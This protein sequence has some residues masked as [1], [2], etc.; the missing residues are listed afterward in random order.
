MVR[1]F[2]PDQ[3][4]GHFIAVDV[5]SYHDCLKALPERHTTTQVRLTYQGEDLRNLEMFEIPE[6]TIIEVEVEV[7]GG[8]GGFG[9]LLRI[10]AAQKKHFNNFDSSR[11]SNGRR[12]RDIKN[13][14]RLKEYVKRKRDEKKVLDEELASL[15]VQQDNA[16]VDTNLAHRTEVEQQYKHRVAQWQSD[17]NQTVRKGLLRQKEK[18]AKPSAAP[19][20]QATLQAD[21]EASSRLGKRVPLE[22]AAVSEID[23]HTKKLVL[24]PDKADRLSAAA[25]QPSDTPKARLP[26]QVAGVT[27]TSLMP[28]SS[29]PAFEPIELGD[30]QSIDDLHRLSVDH[31]KHELKRLGLK[32]GGAPRDR[33]QRLWDIKC[34]PANLLNPKYLAK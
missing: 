29:R 15:K 12:L 23:E 19:G 6:L 31:V 8:K 20:Q 32:C 10:A 25:N 18:A 11:D 17:L 13:E 30:L 1:V 5:D 16:T 4:E 9:S 21:D 14:I 27:A 33:V 26:A 22:Q 2:L 7:L 28:A 24:P 3:A 34:N